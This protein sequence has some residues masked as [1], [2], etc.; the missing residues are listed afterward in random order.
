MTVK[1]TY[2]YV[3]QC[4]KD[5]GCELLQEFY[6][7]NKEKLKYQCRCRNISEISFSAFKK[8]V[9][10]MKCAGSEK[11]TY[12]YVQQYFKDNSCELLEKFYKNGHTNMQYQCECGN[13]SEISF[14]RFQSGQRCKKCGGNEKLI[15]E[16][17][18]QY[19]KDN[20]CELLEKFY[21]NA[22]LKMKYRCIC[23]R[24]V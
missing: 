22:H 9:R 15:Y 17:V 16:Y 14:S 18:Y 8:G 1:H 5:N 12:E 23:N 7:N 3:Q 21:E 19:F 4:F 6:K 20:G 10:C 24:V 11:L 2:E 13:I